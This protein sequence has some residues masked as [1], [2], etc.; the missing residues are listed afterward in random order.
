MYRVH[1][2][3]GC[4]YI[5][6]IIPFFLFP[7]RQCN[8]R[9]ILSQVLGQNLHCLSREQT[10]ICTSHIC[11]EIWF[12]TL[13]PSYTSWCCMQGSNQSFCMDICAYVFFYSCF[14]FQTGNCPGM[15]INYT[16]ATTAPRWSSNLMDVALFSCR[17]RLCFLSPVVKTSD[18]RIII[19]VTLII[20]ILMYSVKPGRFSGAIQANFSRRGVK[21]FVLCVCVCVNYFNVMK[22]IQH[23]FGAVPMPMPSLKRPSIWR[24]ARNLFPELLT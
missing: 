16:L 7:E 20:R 5:F 15:L 4:E 18:L 3:R 9:Q 2:S 23:L 17:T 13:R 8:I 21:F 11:V 22:Y 6:H 24:S 10:S 12:Q 1:S 14:A 19:T